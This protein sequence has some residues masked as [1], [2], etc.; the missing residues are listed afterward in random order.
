MTKGAC[1]IRGKDGSFTCEVLSLADCRDAQGLFRG[2]GSTCEQSPCPTPVVR[3]A[4]CIQTQM[5]RTC[6][7]VTEPMCDRLRG[8]Y[9]GNNTVCDDVKC[10]DA[11]EEC[12]CDLNGDGVLDMADF[13]EFIARFDA[14]NADLDGDGDSDADDLMVFINCF[15]EG[16]NG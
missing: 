2:P 6:V 5:G 12:P 8:R 1:C 7:L 11:S 16:C 13:R 4:C 3:G 14:G 9:A 15:R 10:D